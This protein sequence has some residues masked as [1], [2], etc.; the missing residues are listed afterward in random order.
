[1]VSRVRITTRAYHKAPPAKQNKRGRP[2]FYGKKVLLR[3]YFEHLEDFVTAPSPVYGESNVS[4]QYL[5]MDLLWRPI[6][7][8]VRFVPV[9]YP[10]RGHMILMTTQVLLNTLDIIRIY[11]Y[12]FKIE[13]SFKQAL[14]TLG[15]YRYDFW[16]K[17][18][19][20]SSKEKR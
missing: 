6:G 9:K 1:L 17:G 10:S 15:T 7:Q 12:R 13:V 18:N 14:H 5:Y 20:S 4:I 11:G 3:N 19:A 8:L 16:M 2:K